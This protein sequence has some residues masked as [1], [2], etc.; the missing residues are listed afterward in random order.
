[1]S[2]YSSHKDNPE[3]KKIYAVYSLIECTGVSFA[4]ALPFLLD[5]NF[6]L[7][8]ISCDKIFFLNGCMSCRPITQNVFGFR[9]MSHER[10][11]MGSDNE[12]HVVAAHWGISLV[13][14]LPFVISP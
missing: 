7:K 11:E 2:I 4:C 1:M 14:S 10:E 13:S 5:R 8:N 9:P 3:D 12:A 6:L